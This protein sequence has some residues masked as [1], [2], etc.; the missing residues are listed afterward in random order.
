MTRDE[1]IRMLTDQYAQT[2]TREVNLLRR[3]EDEAISKNP[4]IGAL[5]AR[6]AALPIESMRLA[7]AD[8]AN[9]SEISKR[10]REAG[11]QLNSDIRRLLSES[12][13]PEDYLQMHYACRVCRD[14]GYTGGIPERMCD[15][16]LKRLREIERE[17]DGVADLS[18]QNFAAYDENRI[19]DEVVMGNT[20]QRDLTARIR[21]LCEEYANDYP[22]C[23]KPNLMLTGEA[24]LGKTFLLSAIAERI[25]SRGYPAVIISAYKLVEIMREKHF[26]MESGD[27]D[28][29]RLMNC[30]L[31]LI[32]DLGC[33]P[34]LRNITQEYLF[35]L[36]NDRIVKKKHTVIATNLTPPML[37]E[38]YGERIMSRLCDKTVTDSVRLMG[39]D[40]RR[41]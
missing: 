11:L 29:E 19:P 5:L 6:R 3:R 25:E 41:I 12:G 40:L 21:D 18:S 35:I 15:C 39:K 17:T 1:A 22:K 2:R 9:A 32:D 13:F 24:G 7:M 38:R 14:T 4:E 8:Q 26:H 27:G 30:P 20:T 31:L 37:K 36:L 10:M 34:M 16:F 28:F 23:Y 33:E